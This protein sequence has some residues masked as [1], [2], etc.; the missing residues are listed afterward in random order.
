MPPPLPLRV[1]RKIRRGE[2]VD[3]NK[4]T[5]TLPLFQPLAK[6]KSAK[7]KESKRVL[8]DLTTWLEAWNLLPLGLLPNLCWLSTKRW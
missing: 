6:Q 3:F 1:R 7:R 2:Y 8:T 4:P 5:H